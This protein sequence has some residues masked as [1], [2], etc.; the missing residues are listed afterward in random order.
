MASQKKCI[1]EYCKSC[2]YDPTQPGSWRFQIENCST[3]SC[4][5]YPVRPLTS[6]TIIV[7]RRE[8]M[9]TK[10]ENE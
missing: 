8:R 1:E 3:V 7:Q 10:E 6:E 2:S 9:S 4:A 5:L